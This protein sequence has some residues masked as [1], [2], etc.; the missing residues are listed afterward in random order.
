[1]RYVEPVFRPPSE[2]DSYILQ[3]TI[4]CSWNHCTYCAMYRNKQYRV[5]PLAET[6]KDIACA[7]DTFGPG[8][9]R[10]FVADGDA[11]AMDMAH[12]VP[13]LQALREA[14]PHLTR[15]SAY[16]TARNVLEKTE[17]E[18][19]SLRELGLS[20][21]YMGPESGDDPTLKAIAKGASF[22]DHVRAAAKARAAAINQSLIFLLGI[23]GTDRSQEHAR[24][25]AALTTAM[26]PRY[27]SLLTVTVLENTPLFQLQTKRRFQV[28]PLDG[29]LEEIRLFIEE[30]RPQNAVFRTNHASNY[31][32]LAG[33]LPRDRDKLLSVI[34]AA[35]RGEV[36]LR[37]EHERGL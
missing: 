7:R 20:L 16:A 12:W 13:I 6:L 5:R 9:R 26:D 2:A 33:R 29:L 14:F 23:A 34:Q 22:D 30:A 24:A 19:Q 25:S 28:P 1:M 11:L 37:A 4:G 3:A 17:P 10:V 36:R 31:L 15:V 21:L 27:V 32:P 8:V 35:R 18:L